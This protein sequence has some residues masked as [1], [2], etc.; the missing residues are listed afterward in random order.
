MD[1]LTDVLHEAGLKRR[2]LDLRNLDDLTALEFPCDRSMGLHVVTRGQIHIHAPSLA[3]PL[4]LAAGSVALMA[5][6][7]TH[8]LSTSRS[9][10]PMHKVS[11]AGEFAQPGPDFAPCP[12]TS[13][14]I[15]GAYQFW[16][17]PI[18]AL[19]REIPDWFVL[20]T[21]SLGS[22]H[23]LTL[24]IGLLDEELRRP[25][26]GGQTIIYGLLDVIFT[27]LIR[28]MVNRI[29]HAKPGWSYAIADLQIRKAVAALHADPTEAWTLDAL[30]GRAG[31]SR[32]VFAERFR[33]AMGDTPLSYLRNLRVQ[34]AMNLLAETPQTLEHVARVAGFSDAFAFSKAFKKI[35][36]QSPKDFRL[37][38]KLDQASPWRLHR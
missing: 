21:Q 38:A 17:N 20:N 19:F 26:L 3:E 12:A 15:S 29:G 27:Y 37:Q 13:S 24:T 8:V 28:E 30:A 25:S 16:N 33:R 23:P 35:V 10:D 4:E 22:F 31:L 11:V 5:R 1:L 7:C 6:G 36:G 9:Y 34:R 2:V 14:L 18:H 32:T